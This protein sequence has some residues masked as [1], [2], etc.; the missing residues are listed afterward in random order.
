MAFKQ[1]RRH[2]F[3]KARWECLY[4]P[5]VYCFLRERRGTSF[6][7]LD[8]WDVSWQGVNLA[9]TG[10]QVQVVARVVLGIERKVPPKATGKTFKLGSEFPVNLR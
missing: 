2:G 3:G 1:W 8:F 4:I 7:T 6:G 10:I 5:E 9:L